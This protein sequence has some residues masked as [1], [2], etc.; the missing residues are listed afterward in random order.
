MFEFGDKVK[1]KVT[2]FEGIVMSITYYHNGCTR[3]AIQG[4]KLKEDGIPT[5][6]EY[7]DIQQLELVE[8]GV[9]KG[10]A[11]MPEKP[12]APGGPMPAPPQ[13]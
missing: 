10:F 6:W 1:D 2:G 11:K 13:M 8:A 4:L 3:V 7:Y 5:G 12:K 9:V